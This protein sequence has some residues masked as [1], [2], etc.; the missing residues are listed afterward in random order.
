MFRNALSKF[1]YQI[2]LFSLLPL[3]SFT[4]TSIEK[5]GWWI[6][7]FFPDL[8]EE[9]RAEP[10]DIEADEGFTTILPCGPPE[11]YPRPMVTWKRDG[12][13]VNLDQRIH[14]REE[15][16]N[17]IIQRL[18]KEDEGQYQCIISNMA[19]R[20]ESSLARLHVRRKWILT[21]STTCVICWPIFELWFMLLLEK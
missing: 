6:C 1:D 10:T 5:K 17:L 2:G 11:G 21:Q 16:G 19:G 13:Y 15:S 14:I 7:I 4:P 12:E 9:F 18:F 3:A 20:R 8:G